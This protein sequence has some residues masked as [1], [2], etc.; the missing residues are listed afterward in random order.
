LRLERKGYRGGGLTLQ[1]VGK[2]KPEDIDPS[3]CTHINY[4][5]AVL[6]PTRWVRPY[7]DL[8]PDETVS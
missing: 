2:Y 5:F 1:G 3:L 4:G 6:D 7:R 8:A